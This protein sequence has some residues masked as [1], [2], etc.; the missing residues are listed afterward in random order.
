MKWL[1]VIAVLLL[2]ALTWMQFQSRR[3]L[4]AGRALAV[5]RDVSAALQSGSVWSLDPATT[6]EFCR[7]SG[8]T[9]DDWGRLLTACKLATQRGN[10][11]GERAADAVA[12]M[13][14][15]VDVGYYALAKEKLASFASAWDHAEPASK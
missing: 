8:V 7:T 13:R 9:W 15:A 11:D 2:A 3:E 12:A 14:A 6:D 4:A 1:L 5:R 10:P